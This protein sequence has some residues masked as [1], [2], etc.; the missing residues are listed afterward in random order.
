M[1]ESNR[2]TVSGKIIITKKRRLMINERR[3]L[4]FSIYL[5]KGCEMICDMKALFIVRRVKP[6]A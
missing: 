3:F 1:C 4:R 5:K 6:E 2:Q